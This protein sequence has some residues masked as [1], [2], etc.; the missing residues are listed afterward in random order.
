MPGHAVT[1]TDPCRGVH[2]RSA[3]AL[4]VVSAFAILFGLAYF[5]SSVAGHPLVAPSS[6][7]TP[8]HW[9]RPFYSSIVTYTTLGFGDVTP[10]S[11]AGTIVVA[12]EAICGYVALG[13]LIAIL[14]NKVARR[15]G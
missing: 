7:G 5:T 4:R 10:A 13:L 9:L 3:Q 6:P 14:A 2:C 11:V 15:A 1:Q 8:E 12:L